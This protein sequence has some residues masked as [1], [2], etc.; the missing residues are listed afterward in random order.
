MSPSCARIME[1]LLLRRVL[2][3][4]AVIV[5]LWN[6]VLAVVRV[7]LV[8]ATCCTM[9]NFCCVQFSSRN[10]LLVSPMFF[11]MQCPHGRQNI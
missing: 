6:S 8:Y 2:V 3:Q 1:L 10:C 7:V 4:R 9:C 5:H 11:L